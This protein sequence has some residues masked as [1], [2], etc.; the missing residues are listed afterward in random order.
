MTVRFLAMKFL[1]VIWITSSR[2]LQYYENIVI[3][4]N[5]YLVFIENTCYGVPQIVVFRK[6]VYVGGLL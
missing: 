5:F 6:F 2:I 1:E 4:H 3:E